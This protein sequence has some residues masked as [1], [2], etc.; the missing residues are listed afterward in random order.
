MVHSSKY[1]QHLTHQFLINGLFRSFGG[2][3]LPPIPEM[4]FEEMSFQGNPWGDMSTCYWH[5]MTCHKE[6]ETCFWLFLA[7]CCAAKI[8]IRHVVEYQIC[9]LYLKK[10]ILH[11]ILDNNITTKC[12]WGSR[13]VLNIKSIIKQWWYSLLLITS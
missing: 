1:E 8:S 9:M 5:A 12:K 2:E 7:S 4:L 13:G 11:I 3:T 10:H 6:M